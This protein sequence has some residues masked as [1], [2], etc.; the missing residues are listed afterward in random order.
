MV[1]KKSKV[2]SIDFIPVDLL[3]LDSQNPRF[4]GALGSNPSQSRIL[5]FIAQDVG[6]KDLL[7]SMSHSGYYLSAPLIGIRQKNS[8]RVVIV[9]GN[10]RL[11]TALILLGDERASGQASRAKA[12]PIENSTRAKL[13]ELPVLLVESRIAVLPYLGMAH[14]VGN[15]TWDSHAKAAWAVKVLDEHLYGGLPQ[16]AEE[17]GD[18]NRTLE[19]MVEAYRLVTQLEGS[20]RFVPNDSIRKGRGSAPYPFSWV[21]TALQFSSIRRYLSLTANEQ[22]ITAPNPV[23]PEK[24]DSAAELLGWMFGNKSKGVEPRLEDSRQIQ[25]LAAA[26]TNPVQISHMRHGLNVLAS[27]EAVR[28]PAERITDRLVQS[29]ELLKG[30]VGDLPTAT[31]GDEEISGL[32]PIARRVRDL[33]TAILKS[34]REAEDRDS[35]DA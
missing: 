34:L 35:D 23:P 11:A 20:G 16:I 7:S 9:E 14:I 30:V 12:H 31:L 29:E 8:D 25:D 22:V 28:P 5:D 13:D 3:D 1:L 18:T 27:R 2:Q 33:S 19:R 21:Y 32:L 17:I 4:A 24:L 26:V 10:R 15:K 6:I